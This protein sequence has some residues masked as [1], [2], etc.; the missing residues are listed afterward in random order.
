MSVTFLFLSLDDRHIYDHYKNLA[1]FFLGDKSASTVTKLESFMAEQQAFMQKMADGNKNDP[2]WRN[3]GLVLDQY[4]GLT[5]GYNY[6][7]SD[8]MVSFC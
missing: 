8:H 6:A 4:M 2:F 3:V 5:E 7:A 1:A